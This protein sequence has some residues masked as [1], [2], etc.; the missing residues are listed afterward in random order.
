MKYWFFL[1]FAIIAEVIGSV[2]LKASNGFTRLLPSIVVVVGFGISFFLF[3]HAIKVISLGVAY[4]IWSGLGIF[5]IATIAWLFYGQK[6]DF[7]AIVGIVL[8]LA[9]VLVLRLLSN[10]SVD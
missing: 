9:G 2:A 5:L 7:W 4:A 6:L 8:I 1:L 3:S 10:T